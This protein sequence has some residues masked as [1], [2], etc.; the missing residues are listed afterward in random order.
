MIE[1]HIIP[2]SERIMEAMI[3]LTGLSR[4]HR[5]IVAGS[6]A[7]DIYV[8]LHH[9]G[10]SRAATTTTC[11]VPCGQHD[12]ALV[13][14]AHSSQALEALLARVVSF[15]NARATLGVWVESQGH[16]RSRKLSTLLG[17]LGFRIEAGAKCENG[18]VFSARRSEPSHVANAA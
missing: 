8:S 2:S 18:F 14:G 7:F 16:H 10:F 6:N 9:R 5:V 13:A 3:D 4:S 1:Q 12:V 11:R 15:L 17:E